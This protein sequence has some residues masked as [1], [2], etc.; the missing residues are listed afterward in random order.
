MKILDSYLKDYSK[1]MSLGKFEN[2]EMPLIDAVFESLIKNQNYKKRIFSGY[3]CSCLSAY[4][5]A[6]SEAV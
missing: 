1:N 2:N 4:V 3:S 6:S 5:I